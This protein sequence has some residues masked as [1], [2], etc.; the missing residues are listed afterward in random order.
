MR[1]LVKACG[2]VPEALGSVG[3]SLGFVAALV[4]RTVEGRGPTARA[5]SALAVGPLVS[6]FGDGVLDLPASQVTPVAT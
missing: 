3:S 2:H 6:A 1:S 4:H 5:T